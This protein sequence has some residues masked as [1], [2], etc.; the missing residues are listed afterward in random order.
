MACQLN[1]NPSAKPKSSN[2]KR[3]CCNYLYQVHILYA[4]RITIFSS[5]YLVSNGGAYK[6]A[7]ILVP[8]QCLGGHREYFHLHHCL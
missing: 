1:I 6:H 5:V 4:L 7:I 8:S 2:T 3:A